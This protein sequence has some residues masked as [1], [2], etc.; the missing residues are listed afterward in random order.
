MR[1]R[2]A[3]EQGRLT[4]APL[5]FETVA[6]GAADGS[7]G[8]ATDFEG[9]T[10]STDETCYLSS[11]G[12]QE[13]EPRVAPSIIAYRA[14]RVVERLTL[15]DKVRPIIS[16]PA[17]RGA[18]RNEAFEGLALTPDGSRLIAASESA[19]VQDGDRPTA[20]RG[21]LVRIVT[22]DRVGQ[23]FA[24][25]AEYAYPVGKVDIPSDYEGPSGAVGLVEILPLDDGSL[26]SMERTFV[27]ETTGAKRSLN[28]IT[29][30]RTSF[31]GATDVRTL[32]SLR[33]A[34]RVRPMRKSRILSLG[35]IAPQLPPA[36][37]TLDNFEGLSVGPRL[38]NGD[39]TLLLVSD[40]NF[41]TSQ[42]TAFLLL[43]VVPAP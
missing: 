27:R 14:G 33:G 39:S 3:V 24:P 25:G 11:E 1:F 7:E 23:R 22:F 37:A 32:F 42:V 34:P 36:L 38:P 5:G 41:S 4:V 43:R 13:G 21:T 17:T 18:R 31:K 10:C 6:M 30:F 19:L 16:G 15:P 9:L 26:L 35:D 8:A 20:D 28:H 40:D 12:N 29:I 2:V